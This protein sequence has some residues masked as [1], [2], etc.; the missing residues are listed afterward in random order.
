M[1]N[2]DWEKLARDVG[3]LRE[4]GEHGSDDLA[5]R[6]LAMTL[7]DDAIKN[8]VDHAISLRPGFNLARSVLWLLRPWAAME[9]CK[10]IYDSEAD[11]QVK[12]S[13]VQLLSSAADHRALPWVEEFLAHE[14]ASIQSCGADLLDQLLW[15][16]FVE[17]S[18]CREL[19]EAM[20]EHSCESVREKHD[21]IQRYLSERKED[22]SDGGPTQ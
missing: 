20:R 4:D 11:A 6:A 12:A 22:A 5:K 10:E 7:G 2:L 21:W 18:E 9:R 19:L 17:P 8:A 14:D 16:G 1:T 15:C 13:A 3:S